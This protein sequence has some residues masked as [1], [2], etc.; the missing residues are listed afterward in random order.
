[1]VMIYER[2]LHA[3]S[4]RNIKIYQLR[5]ALLRIPPVEFD[6]FLI[7]R[8]VL[9][10][11]LSRV[12]TNVKLR[13]ASR[14]SE[15]VVAEIFAFLPPSFPNVVRPCAARL[16]QGAAEA[17]VVQILEAAVRIGARCKRQ[18]IWGSDVAMA[19]AIAGMDV[20]P[21]SINGG[22]G[23]CPLCKGPPLVEMTPSFRA[24]LRAL[25]CTAGVKFAHRTA[26]D[27]A[28]LAAARFCR[29]VLAVAS[30][31]DNGE[32][33]DEATLRAFARRWSVVEEVEHDNDND[34]EDD[35]SDDDD[36]DSDDDSVD[37]DDNASD[38]DSD[39]TSDDDDE[40]R[41]RYRIHLE[42]ALVA[43]ASQEDDAPDQDEGCLDAGAI[44]AAL[45][46]MKI[47]I[48]WPA[49]VEDAA[50]I[51][52]AELGVESYFLP[53]MQPVEM[54]LEMPATIVAY[55]PLCASTTF[56]DIREP[57][58]ERVQLSKLKVV[59][60]DEVEVP[61]HD[62]REE[63]PSSD[64]SDSDSGPRTTDLNIFDFFG[65]KWLDRGIDV[66]GLQLDVARGLVDQLN[67]PSVISSPNDVVDAVSR[68]AA[69]EGIVVAPGAMA[70]VV[71][72]AIQYARELLDFAFEYASCHPG[73]RRPLA[74]RDACTAILRCLDDPDRCDFRRYFRLLGVRPPLAAMLNRVELACLNQLDSPPAFLDV[75]HR[76][77]LAIANIG[78][79]DASEKLQPSAV[80]EP[81]ALAALAAM[82]D[83]TVTSFLQRSALSSDYVRTFVT[84]VLGDGWLPGGHV[85]RD[86]AE[87]ALLVV[88]STGHWSHSIFDDDD[89]RQ[90]RLN[91]PT[92]AA[93]WRG[94]SPTTQSYLDDDFRNLAATSTSS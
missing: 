47:P 15:V 79:D 73:R 41:K 62:V 82:L 50:V 83:L 32:R 28:A 52:R 90:P 12:A 11:Q 87:L 27:E 53:P 33:R 2:D 20:K 74:P 6:A 57:T 40:K 42:S 43:A 16:L 18:G 55:C 48:Y 88:T 45:A 94:V 36:N 71:R 64:D 44:K 89:V 19:L 39:D 31:V 91:P 3:W 7:R 37:Y 29:Q 61:S 4:L 5:A 51:E 85:T 14:L 23:G 63:E 75:L 60:Y 8:G 84:A 69:D 77:A 38:D 21:R 35:D 70:T 78:V 68:V 34:E 17:F 58:T 59:D 10:A 54:S 30:G 25:A 9:G 86:D 72:Y 67:E 93:S 22:G 81:T 26:I 92:L 66:R 1:M 49:A 76:Q 46:K 24:G 13:L 65:N 56:T 80:Y